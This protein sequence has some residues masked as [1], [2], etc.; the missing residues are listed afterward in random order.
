MQDFLADMFFNMSQSDIIKTR[1]FENTDRQ[2]KNLGL[3]LKPFPT[4]I[5]SAILC[6]NELLHHIDVD[7]N[8]RAE[9]LIV[10]VFEREAEG[11]IQAHQFELSK[12]D[13]NAI[14]MKVFSEADKLDWEYIETMTI[15]KEIGCDK[16]A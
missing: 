2:T 8:F 15:S 10:K 9:I 12:M 14:L 1:Y 13:I 6:R 16:I 4:T 7:F 5:V 11:I 3:T